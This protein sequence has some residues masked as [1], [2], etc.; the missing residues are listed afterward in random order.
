MGGGWVGAGGGFCFGGRL[1]HLAL[2]AAHHPPLC[3]LP[4]PPPPTPAQCDPATG[5]DATSCGGTC[6]S[7]CAPLASLLASI[8]A[9]SCTTAT[10]AADCAAGQTCSQVA[11]R[12]CQRSVCDEATGAITDAPCDG[13]CVSGSAPVLTAARL[14]D[15]GRQVLLTFDQEV[16]LASSAPRW[17]GGWAARVQQGRSAGRAR[18]IAWRADEHGCR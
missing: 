2:P 14:S 16:T 5:F 11:G 6:A 7:R 8:N 10:A 4:L 15:D 3:P 1:G 17:A 13:F 18:G 12:T 9:G